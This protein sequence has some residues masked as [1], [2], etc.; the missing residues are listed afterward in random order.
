MSYAS[1]KVRTPAQP[2][3]YTS[4]CCCIILLLLLQNQV[5]PYC[6]RT[7]DGRGDSVS[8]RF[9]AHVLHCTPCGEQQQPRKVLP[10]NKT[11]KFLRQ[12]AMEKAPFH[13]VA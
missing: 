7:F 10:K 13:I 4:L 1:A 5:C 2:P 6:L 3:A 9:T 11:V 8:S 12:K